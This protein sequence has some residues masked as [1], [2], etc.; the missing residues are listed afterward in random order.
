MRLSPYPQRLPE[1]V[2]VIPAVSRLT[3]LKLR[4]K[5]GRERLLAMSEDGVLQPAEGDEPG[6]DQLW[7]RGPHLAATPDH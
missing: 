4:P 6:G 7:A 3:S 1:D 5:E 2:G